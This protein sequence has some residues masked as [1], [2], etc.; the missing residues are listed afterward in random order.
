MNENQK[1]RQ[2]KKEEIRMRITGMHCASCAV[3]IEKRLKKLEGLEA[4]NVSFSNEEAR[5][6]FD[7]KKTSMKNVVKAVREVGYDVLK[8]E[9]GFTLANLSQADGTRIERKLLENSGII[10]VRANPMAKTVY[11][12]YNPEETSV[13]N[14]KG[15]LTDL[16]FKIKTT[17]QEET[18]VSPEEKVFQ[19]KITR[20]KRRS[21]VGILFTTPILFLV[22]SG[23]SFPSISLQF[24]RVIM[25]LLATPVQFYSGFTFY[26]SGLK[27]LSNRVLNMDVLV[28]LGTS[29][30]Y[31]YSLS[32][33]I[34][35]SLAP[36]IFY[37]A[38]TSV[39]T[40]V[41]LGRYFEEKTK[42][43]TNEAVRK[44]MELKPKTARVKR[45]ETYEEVPIS[46]VEVKDQVLVRPGEKIPVDGVITEGNGYVD[47]SMVT[48]ESMPVK[49]MEKDA[50]IGGTI[51]ENGSITIS[52]T[53]VGRNTVLDQITK[54]VKRARTSKPPIQSTVDSVVSI[55]VPVIITIAI[56]TGVSWLLFSAVPYWRA[57]LFT[58]SVLVVACPCAL[59]LA[60]PTALT[61]GLGQGAKAGLVTRNGEAIELMQKIDTV[62]LDKTGTLTI[63][64]P[65]VT[66]FILVTK[67]KSR[68]ELIQLA[69][70]AEK[71]SEHPLAEAIVEYAKE[72]EIDISKDPKTFENIPGQGVFTQIDD[73]TV[74][75][76]NERLA[77]RGMGVNVS[78][79]KDQVEKLQ[80]EAK[81]VIYLMI[82]DSVVGIIGIADKIKPFAQE[83]IQQLNE[84]SKEVIMLTGDTKKT[85]HAIANRLGIN[86]VFA[87]VLPED[88]TD[89][90]RELQQEGRRVAMVGDG[91]ND[92]P[93]LAQADVGIAMGGGTDIAAEAGDVILMRDDLRAIIA[94]FELSN[95]VMNKIKQNLFWAFA[96]NVAL[97]PIAAGILFP[98]GFTL[99][100]EWAGL[101]MALSSISVTTL[102]L[103]LKRWKPKVYKEITSS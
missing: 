63:G 47:E 69:G 76:G 2:K 9:V 100:P 72:K 41:V 75:L 22:Y 67:E 53:R 103:L 26:K 33:T 62:V 35:P 93:S 96:Y 77:T 40:F 83:V 32:G 84:M 15:D 38:S 16:G 39:I 86:D 64:K 55:F 85:A 24:S 37:E 8:E 61:V 89:K 102:S 54:L 20:L 70:I 78:H 29:T 87:E 6:E 7:K 51:L 36:H 45:E 5:V 80:K 66:D 11:I 17:E 79:L 13:S 10:D 74:A 60:T 18:G 81:T 88:K 23:I 49:K 101:A 52:A 90:I 95:K 58:V 3:T 59:G 48:G 94:F 57:L 27:G 50:V 82:E 44:L 28:L 92:A 56:V 97:V 14:I 42:M 12:E 25:L 4:S 46:E 65:Q 91:I 73:T 21:L 30:A 31:F 34:L 99:Q 68:N 19:E 71:K 1:T 98:F 43:R